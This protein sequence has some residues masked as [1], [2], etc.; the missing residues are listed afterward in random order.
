[1]HE[2]REFGEYVVEGRDCTHMERAYF[3]EEGQFNPFDFFLE[4]PQ[5]LNPHEFEVGESKT[6][7][8][9]L[10]WKEGASKDWAVTAWGTRGEVRVENLNG[11]ESDHL[12]SI[13]DPDRH[14]S[15]MLDWGIL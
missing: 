13:N 12:P 6:F 1:M 4:G 5:W 15:G 8:V 9:L 10:D 14:Q 11:Q 2:N 7:I 3:F